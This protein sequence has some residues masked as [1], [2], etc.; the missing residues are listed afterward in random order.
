MSPDPLPDPVVLLARVEDDIA[1]GEVHRAR[2]RLKTWLSQF[3]SEARYAIRYGE[4]MVEIEEWPQAGHAFV[5]GGSMDVGH[6]ELMAKSLKGY[7]ADRS[8][9][10]AVRWCLARANEGSELPPSILAALE[11]RGLDP[12]DE[13]KRAVADLA[14]MERPGSGSILTTVGCAVGAGLFLLVVVLGVVSLIGIVA[15]WF[16]V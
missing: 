5:Q 4:L 13:I 10:V 12:E 1:R 2:N 8:I 9:L 14:R 11:E 7:P 6:Q 3:P 15:G 16:G